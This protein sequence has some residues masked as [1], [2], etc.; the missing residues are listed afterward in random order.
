LRLYVSVISNKYILLVVTGP[1]EVYGGIARSKS[2][3]SE[4]NA[5]P[6]LDKCAPLTDE[7]IEDRE[8]KVEP[9]TTGRKEET[10]LAQPDPRAA[11]MAMLLKRAPH[12]KVDEPEVEDV[13]QEETKPEPRLA[14]KSMLSK[15][16]P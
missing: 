9:L 3:E 11:L 12:S 7:G 6:M 8:L 15:R 4:E 13:E 16:S 14:F 1:E 5:D 2:E 10:K